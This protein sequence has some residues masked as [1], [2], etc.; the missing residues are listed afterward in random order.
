MVAYGHDFNPIE[1]I[2]AQVKLLFKKERMNAML[3]G[4]APD[5]EKLLR[6]IMM[7]YSPEKIASIC[8]GTYE[9]MLL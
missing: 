4:G 6:S 3:L 8:K 7:A 9:S 1:R 2:W 5:F